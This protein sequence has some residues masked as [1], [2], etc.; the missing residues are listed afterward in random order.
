MFV[1]KKKAL[2]RIT[3]LQEEVAHERQL[4]SQA[5]QHADESA[6]QAAH[7]RSRA[8]TAE[9]SPEI[10]ADTEAAFSR[11]ALHKSKQISAGLSTTTRPGIS[12]AIGELRTTIYQHL[13]DLERGLSGEASSNKI[14]INGPGQAMPP[15]AANIN[16][17]LD[18]T[19]RRSP[20]G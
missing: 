7:W 10:K 12:A 16:E 5:I 18:R 11:G 19:H 4:A 9:S 2:A 8:E 1:L 13:D 3:A 20:R 14:V 6:R 17:V 15:L